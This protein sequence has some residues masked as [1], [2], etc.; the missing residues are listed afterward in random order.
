MSTGGAHFDV[1]S[2][3]LQIDVSRIQPALQGVAPAIQRF[4]QES[5]KRFEGLRANV[6]RLAESMT[7]LADKAQKAFAPIRAGAENVSRALAGLA[8]A[9][10]GSS[11]AVTKLAS[12]ANEAG[13][14]FSFVF[15]KAAEETG[16]K[17]DEFSKSAGRSKYDLRDM[18]SNI[19]ALIGPMGFTAK[20]TGELSVS[21]TKLATDLS[22]FFNVRE[23]DALMAL[24]SAIVGES[25]PMRRFGVQLNELK[26]QREAF[27]L[28]IAHSTKEVQGAIKTQAIFSIV[29]RE[30]K[31]A[32]GDAVRTGDMLAN[33]W[34]RMTSFMK[35]AGTDI[36]QAFIPTATKL[37]RTIGD[38]A[39]PMK[40]WAAAN[41]EWLS[42]KIANG[43]AIAEKAAISFY[44]T[45]VRA[46][47]KMLPVMV[48]LWDQGKK[49]YTSF[50]LWFSSL[51][52]GTQDVLKIVGALTGLSVVLGKIGGSIPVIG[53]FAQSLAGV[54]SPLRLLT[55]SLSFLTNGISL[56]RTLLTVVVPIIGGLN[57]IVL[58]IVAVLG[59]LAAAIKVL[60]DNFPGFAKRFDQGLAGIKASVGFVVE[61]FKALLDW[62]NGD[63]RGLELMAISFEKMW[64][65]SIASV[66]KSLSQMMRDIPGMG[67]VADAMHK[68]AVEIIHKNVG[69]GDR[70]REIEEQRVNEKRAAQIAAGGASGEAAAPASEIEKLLSGDLNK[71]LNRHIGKAYEFSQTRDQ[72]KGTRSAGPHL[73][74][75]NRVKAE[76]MQIVGWAAGLEG[77]ERETMLAH[78]KTLKAELDAMVAGV[79][80]GKGGDAAKAAGRAHAVH[81]K[82][83][84]SLRQAKGAD[85]MRARRRQE[86][87]AREH[88]PGMQFGHEGKELGG[89]LEA[90]RVEWMRQHPELE[91][92]GQVAVDKAKEQKEPDVST[93]KGR[94]AIADQAAA[95]GTSRLGALRAANQAA[96]ANKAGSRLAALAEAAGKA[97][98]GA[99]Q[100][101]GA[102][103]KA[104]AG[105]EKL[106]AGEDDL[107]NKAEAGW[108]DMFK[109]ANEGW[110]DMFKNMQANFQQFIFAP[111]Q[112]F[113]QALMAP[114]QAFMQMLGLPFQAAQQAQQAAVQAVTDQVKATLEGASHMGELAGPQVQDIIDQMNQAGDAKGALNVAKGYIQAQIQQTLANVANTGLDPIRQS[115][116]TLA[117]P[118]ILPNDFNELLRTNPQ[119]AATLKMF[120][121]LLD[122]LDSIKVPHMA[123]GGVVT[124]PTYALVGERGPE[125]VM[126]LSF[127]QRLFGNPANIFPGAGGNWNNFRL[128]PG[129]MAINAL[130][131]NA[132]NLGFFQQMFNRAGGVLNQQLD[133][134]NAG[135]GG[136]LARWGQVQ[137]Q[138]EDS[139]GLVRGRRSINLGGNASWASGVAPGHT[140]HFNFGDIH[141]ANGTDEQVASLAQRISDAVRSQGRD[142]TGRSGLGYSSNGRSSPLAPAGQYR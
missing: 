127:L 17:L 28:G 72:R 132:G 3:R 33:S 36:G 92:G 137:Q 96:N 27:R 69:L 42:S 70:A 9:A 23:S 63:G 5:S 103:N 124:S 45:S 95:A 139:L 94:K 81:A 31:Q 84:R 12:D 15:G 48:E 18:A 41:R 134:G 34:R 53:P 115:F 14:K 10:A 7:Q 19:G 107:H 130:G 54:I 142:I 93:A 104:A 133:L 22:S 90:G 29:M 32:Q 75:M 112:A 100:M 50:M 6:Q 102:E 24:R 138:L 110:Q 121:G 141:L 135:A 56:L 109:K 55:G 91:A 68:K 89:E 71:E 43:M 119:A 125:A 74:A 117:N 114:W 1:L 47:Q 11:V 59:A 80:R 62:F 136:I 83:T 116:G 35:D 78:A 118:G 120:Q 13:S 39:E 67:P 111:W 49:L 129:G 37:V 64:N 60:Y 88:A 44:E 8:T 40:K 86:L 99:E 51:P 52:Q 87:Q 108:G 77:E 16:K 76:Y 38:M 82:A 113:Q 20:K 101:A 79:V 105:A 4:A 61:A 123:E 66:L 128:N 25:E 122:K 85:Q 46:Y 30:T 2:G 57:P 131:L 21:F 65:K 73:L 106:A 58:L 97:A 126:P 26:I 98:K 140:M